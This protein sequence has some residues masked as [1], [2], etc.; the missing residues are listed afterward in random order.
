MNTLMEFKEA[1][2]SKDHICFLGSGREEED[3]FMMM[4]IAKFLHKNYEH[5]SYAQGGYKGCFGTSLYYLKS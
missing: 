2:C 5:I 3:Q 4:A 1:N